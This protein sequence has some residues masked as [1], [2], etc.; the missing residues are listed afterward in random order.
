MAE[1]LRAEEAELLEFVQTQNPDLAEELARLKENNPDLYLQKLRHIKHMRKM[2]EENP[3]AA[4]LMKDIHVRSRE[5]HELG[6]S[7]HES[8]SDSEKAE[9]EAEIVD[10]ATEIFEMKQR[11]RTTRIDMMKQHI[12]ELKQEIKD[13]Q[14]DKEAIVDDFV[15]RMLTKKRKL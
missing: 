14:A 15:Q 4:A 9:I 2:A 10:L 13:R 1:E 8:D 3:E 6:R 11:E 7:Y 12:D 5:L